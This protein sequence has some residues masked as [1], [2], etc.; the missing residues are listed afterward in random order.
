MVEG[1]SE[2]VA[3]GG[4]AGAD[5]PP[6]DP[7]PQPATSPMDSS[8]TAR[9]AIRTNHSWRLVRIEVPPSSAFAAP[10][11]LVVAAAG[12]PR[13]TARPTRTVKIYQ[14][15]RAHLFDHYVEAGRFVKR[16]F[17]APLNE[18]PSLNRPQLL[19]I[20]YVLYAT[21]HEDWRIDAFIELLAKGETYG[22][23]EELERMEGTLL[24]YEDWQTD[25]HINNLRSDRDIRAF[26]KRVKC[27]D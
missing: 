16:E 3:T 20:R 24:G 13:S 9:P 1:V 19:G 11:L 23:S 22:W 25:I 17:V 18:A 6:P 26:W 21:S 12:S 15:R 2:I 14:N 27:G 10:S 4:A 8:A 5:E 7:P